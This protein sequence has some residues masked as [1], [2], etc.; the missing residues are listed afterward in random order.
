VITP[1]VGAIY[2]PSIWDRWI[3][4]N[5]VAY[6]GDVLVLCDLLEGGFINAEG[7]VIPEATV[8]PD[9]GVDA[10]VDGGKK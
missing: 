5:S 9:A 3:V 2:A 7:H 4:F 8:E 1:E 10:G 6:W